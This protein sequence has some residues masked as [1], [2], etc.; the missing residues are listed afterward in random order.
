MHIARD[1]LQQ[2]N[3]TILDDDTVIP[4]KSKCENV[5]VSV[6][7]A[8]PAK[9]V[10]EEESPLEGIRKMNRMIKSLSNKIPSV[11]LGL[12]NSSSIFTST[13]LKELPK[14]VDVAEK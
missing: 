12:W 14:D 7:C 2:S 4:S 10:E 8:I 9:D 11:K 1:L 3:T 13:F 5:R 6:M